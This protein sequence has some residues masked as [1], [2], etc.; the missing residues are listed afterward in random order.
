M[1]P[2]YP[3]GKH[4]GSVTASGRDLKGQA[5]KDG[6]GVWLAIRWVVWMEGMS[7]RWS[8]RRCKRA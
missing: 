8:Q 1:F 5:A 6:E 7:Y 2:F 3:Q 4:T